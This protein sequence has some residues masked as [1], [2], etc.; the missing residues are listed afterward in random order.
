MNDQALKYMQKDIID[1]EKSRSSMNVR[2][3]LLEK[4]IDHL[5]KKNNDLLEKLVDKEILPAGLHPN[6]C[7]C[8]NIPKEYCTCKLW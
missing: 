2:I 3:E 7:T 5:V 8:G 6:T 4:L 1:L